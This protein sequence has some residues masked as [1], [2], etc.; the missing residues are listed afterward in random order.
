MRNHCRVKRL[1]FFLTV[2]M[3][4]FTGCA[5]LRERGTPSAPPANE[6]STFA[7]RPTASAS[8]GTSP[9]E[10][11]QPRSP[12]ATPAPPSNVSASPGLRTAK[13]DEPTGS[14]SLTGALALDSAEGGCAYLETAD[15]KRYQVIY[16][17]GWRVDPATGHLL[18]PDGQDAPVGSSVTVG[19]S[20]APDM[21]SIC[22]IGPIFRATEVISIGG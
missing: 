14:G 22:Q 13:P 15:G 7:D 3:V 8:P 21:A 11:A 1:A 20:M 16:P 4:V 6:D 2:N 9:G 17:D 19:G 18:G 5:L 10:Q 12:A